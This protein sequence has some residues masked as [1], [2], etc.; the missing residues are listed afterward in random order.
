MNLKSLNGRIAL[1]TGASRGIGRGIALRL[2]AEGALVAV[3]YGTRI[4]AAA[5]TVSLIEAAGGTAFAL[6]AE[7]DSLEGVA[8]LLQILDGELIRRTGVNQFDILVNNACIGTSSSLEET[9]E[10]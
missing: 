1:V 5:E 10:E 2:A 6:G 7:L 9:N 3:H 8:R 4:D